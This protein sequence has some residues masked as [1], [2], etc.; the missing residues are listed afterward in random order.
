MPP[1]LVAGAPVAIVA[2][3]RTAL[4]AARSLEG[5]GR[6]LAVFRRTAHLALPGG[7]LAAPCVRGVPPGPLNLVADLP[8]ATDLGLLLAQGEPVL[9][10]GGV[11]L[12]GRLAIDLGR[13]REWSPPPPPAGVAWEGLEGRVRACAIGA[14]GA[15]GGLGPL[16]MPSAG[17]DLAPPPSRLLEA[18]R[19]PLAR[20]ADGVLVRDAGAVREGA[21]SL[22]GLGPGL[23]PS[24]D[25]LLVGLLAVLGLG[26]EGW[27]GGAVAGAAE[28][29]PPF[30]RALLLCACRG[31]L[32]ADVDSLARAVVAGTEG[33]VR[34]AIDDMRGLGAT[35][36][37]DLAAGAAVGGRL[38]LARRRED[39]TTHGGGAACAAGGL[40]GAG[41]RAARAPRTAP[42][43][44]SL[45]P[46]TTH[47]TFPR[48]GQ[49]GSP[50]WS[51]APS[52]TTTRTGTPSS[53]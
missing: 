17:A 53:S 37:T 14:A 44:A 23:T 52:C 13:A 45:P 1:V 26:G 10:R 19:A 30:S 39:T 16:A 9:R 49:A 40:P 20:L 41:R 3:G 12:A 32:G 31:E 11:L 7:A 5:E 25:D 21:R 34:R 18:A 27:V 28:R 50:P 8:P 29:T 15:E 33:E 36:G 4:L 42:G 51:S 6:V 24:G 35:S 48:P 38:L 46:G 47:L 2:A 43:T 22:V